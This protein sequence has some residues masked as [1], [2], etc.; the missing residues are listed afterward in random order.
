MAAMCTRVNRYKV[1]AIATRVHHL[2][3]PHTPLCLRT[4]T[5]GVSSDIPQLHTEN[6]DILRGHVP[7]ITHG[8][9]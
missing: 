4:S 2:R 8:L 3:M 5:R 1:A 6:V 7:T 9:S